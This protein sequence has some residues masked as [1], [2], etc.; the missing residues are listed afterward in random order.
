MDEQMAVRERLVKEQELVTVWTEGDHTCLLLQQQLEE[1]HR[2]LD[3]MQWQLVDAQGQ[4][5]D[6]EQQLDD[7]QRK[8]VQVQ[9]CVY[10]CVCVL[11]C[12][13]A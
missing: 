6:A 5:E 10:V 8:L 7:S 13:C 9:P 1:A 2:R 11:V 12:G 4:L 3:E